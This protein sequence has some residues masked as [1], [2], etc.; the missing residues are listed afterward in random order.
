MAGKCRTMGLR[1]LWLETGSAEA[2]RPALKLYESTGFVR[3]E[4]F[5]NYTADPFSVFMM[6][7]I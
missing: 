4:P 7:A 6:R 5:D 1:S 3:C 2:F